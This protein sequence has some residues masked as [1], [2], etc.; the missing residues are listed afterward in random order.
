VQPPSGGAVS[1]YVVKRNIGKCGGQNVFIDV[2]LGVPLEV[3][4]NILLILRCSAVSHFW[5]V[6]FSD[7][8]MLLLLSKGEGSGRVIW[9]FHHMA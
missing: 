4:P 1:T 8:Q 7:P 5:V 3:L 9:E 2:C 6:S